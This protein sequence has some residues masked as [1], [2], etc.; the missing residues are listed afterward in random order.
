MT[1]LYYY[2]KHGPKR[3]L[4]GPVWR[5]TVVARGGVSDQRGVAPAVSAALGGLSIALDSPDKPL[6]GQRAHLRPRA[7]W[8]W[9]GV[10]VC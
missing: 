8:A 4:A 6:I 1:H 9:D 7:A 5:C 3:A 10:R 2:N